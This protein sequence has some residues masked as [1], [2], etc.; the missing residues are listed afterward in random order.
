MNLLQRTE[1]LV[2]QNWKERK[3]ITLAVIVSFLINGGVGYATEESGFKAEVSK[4]D[5]ETQ[6]P[7][8]NVYEDKEKKGT[9][10]DINGPDSDGVSRNTYS[11]FNMGG[12]N[13]KVLFNNS[14][15]DGKE[16]R[17]GGEGSSSLGFK[18]VHGN[19]NFIG[20][21]SATLIITEIT[22]ETNTNLEGNLEVRND[23]DSKT[24]DLIFAN[25]NGINV[26]GIRYHNVGTVM[27]VNDRDWANRNKFNEHNNSHDGVTTFN[28]GNSKGTIHKGRMNHNNHST[29]EGISYKIEKNTDK[30]EKRKEEKRRLEEERQRLERE[31]EKQEKERQ[32]RLERERREREKQE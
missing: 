9:I 20:K 27:Y 24:A 22:G 13:S 26:N 10:V 17:G 23:E 30:L 6:D 25:E 18:N 14:S 16:N 32:E 12:N 19:K 1:R 7:N 28:E 29:G 5:I 2:K 11:T 3:R 31:R 15:K 21:N 4:V 8:I